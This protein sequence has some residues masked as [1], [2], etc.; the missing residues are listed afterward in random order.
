MKP[1]KEDKPLAAAEWAGKSLPANDRVEKASLAALLMLN[2]GGLSQT[3]LTSEHYFTPANAIIFAAIA[4][5]E[6]DGQPYDAVSICQAIEREGQLE[7]AGGWKY[8]EALIASPEHNNATGMLAEYETELERVRQ[9]RGL[10]RV[11]ERGQ[12]GLRTAGAN[13]EE[14][15]GAIKTGIDKVF[16]GASGDESM[17]EAACAGVIEQI[18][19]I[20]KREGKPLGIWVGV[21]SYDSQLGGLYPGCMDVI[22][23]RPKVGKTAM[24]ETM[25][26]TMLDQ[27]RGAALFQ[28]DMSIEVMIGRIACRRASVVYEDFFRG[29]VKDGELHRVKMEVRRLQKLSRLLRIYNPAG[30]TAMQLGT[31]VRRDKDK[32]GIE[33]FFLDHFQTLRH[34]E[35]SIVDGLTESSKVIRGVTTATKLGAAIIAQIGKEADKSPRPHAGQFKY[36]D[37]LFSDAD[38]VILLWSNDDPKELKPDER[39]E[40]Q[41]TVDANRM[42]PPSDNVMLFHREYMRFEAKA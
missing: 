41:F 7:L 27:G 25:I 22:G 30:L 31:I 17:T 5:A 21:P 16:A 13:A 9:Q 38:R 11:L 8:I 34:D 35:R 32:I 20:K 15:A 33:A 40:I 18:A 19:R 10:W 29:M 12:T 2:L 42:G 23:A 14:L 37:Q 3:N 36:C 24:I 1:R 6:T 39:Q 26:D 4:S 28:M